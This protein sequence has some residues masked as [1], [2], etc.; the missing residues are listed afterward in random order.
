MQKI[1]RPGAIGRRIPKRGHR[2]DYRSCRRSGFS[3]RDLVIEQPPRTRKSNAGKFFPMCALGGLSRTRSR[4]QHLVN[5]ITRLATSPAGGTFYRHSFMNRC[6]K[7]RLVELIRGSQPMNAPSKRL[8]CS[9]SSSERRST[10]S[11]DFPRFPSSTVSS[12]PMINESDYTRLQEVGSVEATRHGDEA[13]PI[14]P[15]VR[16]NWLIFI[17]SDVSD[18]RDAGASRARGTLQLPVLAGLW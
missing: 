4:N 18:V 2:Q 10:V 16:F 1:R 14:I 11:E 12:C 8:A 13:R 3:R 7:C 5:S 17:A 6:R 9:Y 15:W